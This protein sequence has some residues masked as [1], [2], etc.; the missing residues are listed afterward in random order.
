MP[1]A[2]SL[3]IVDKMRS[4]IDPSYLT[5]SAKYGVSLKNISLEMVF[6]AALFVPVPP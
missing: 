6:E 1:A 3:E 2:A 5:A 4:L